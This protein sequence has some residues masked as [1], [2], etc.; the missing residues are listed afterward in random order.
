MVLVPV[1]A[2]VSEDDVRTELA[3]KT[4]ER[5]LDCI[6]MGREIAVPKFV[7]VDRS[8]RRGPEDFAS[9]A[10]CLAGAGSGRT[11]DHPSEFRSRSSSRQLRQRTAT[12]DLD[13]IRMRTEAKDPERRRGS[14]Q[15]QT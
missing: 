7:Q 10:F 2:S 3:S 8:L 6:E 1:V 9:P 11:P 12:P 4:F 13:V 15:V 14:R 5:I